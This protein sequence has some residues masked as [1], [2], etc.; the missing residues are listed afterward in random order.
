MNTPGKNLSQVDNVEIEALS[1]EDLE[2]ASGGCVAAS[3][4]GS[5]CSNG[6]PV[7]EAS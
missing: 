6:K 4:S 2:D 1:D 3:C 5:N 7:K